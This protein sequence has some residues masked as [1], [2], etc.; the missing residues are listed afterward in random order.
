MCT[1]QCWKFGKPSC[2]FDLLIGPDKAGNLMILNHKREDLWVCSGVK[3]R[4]KK[5]KDD[6]VQDGVGPTHV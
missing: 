6:S 3:V 2:G 5:E 4:G 1:N